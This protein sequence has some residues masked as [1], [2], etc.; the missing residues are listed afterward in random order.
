MAGFLGGFLRPAPVSGYGA[1]RVALAAILFAAAGL[2]CHQLATSPVVGDG[3][4]DSRWV[5]MAT[6]EF[7]LFF[8]LW[9]LANLLPKWTHRAAVSCFG[10]FA[11][12][13]LYKALSGYASCGCFGRVEVNPWYTFTLDTAAV[14]SLLRW[15]P[16]GTA[17][18][19]LVP[20]RAFVLRATAVTLAWLSIGFPAAVAMGKYQ[21]TL[22]AEDGVILGDGNLVILEPEKWIGKRFPLLVLCHT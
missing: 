18:S 14:L 9:L 19:S 6:V 1:V 5:L 22:L 2:K 21:P 20:S 3:L 13:S 17:N 7:E 8:G 11:A 4:L 16:S 15:R 12:V 10:L